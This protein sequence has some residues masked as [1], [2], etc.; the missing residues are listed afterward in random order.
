MHRKVLDSYIWRLPPGQR[1]VAIHIFLSASWKE[2]DWATA[3]GPVEV[4]TGE[5]ITTVRKL[6][7]AASVSKGCAERALIA[8]KNGGT[9]TI[10]RVFAAGHRAGQG[11]TRITIR[12]YARYNPLKDGDRDAERDMVSREEDADRPTD[13]PTNSSDTLLTKEE[14]RKKRRAEKRAALLLATSGIRQLNARTGKQYR[15]DGKGVVGNFLALAKD[16]YTEAQVVAVVDAKFKQWFKDPK[17]KEYLVPTTLFR[18]G[19]FRGYVDD[20]GDNGASARPRRPDRTDEEI[21]ADRMKALD[22][23]NNPVHPTE[24]KT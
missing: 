4:A 6:A 24:V 3:A 7:H 23:M 21:E 19:N 22:R 13:R 9:V 11:G 14:R 2:T 20:L 16:G 5:L 1:C 15:D 17:M 18:P 10:E 12:H 8:L